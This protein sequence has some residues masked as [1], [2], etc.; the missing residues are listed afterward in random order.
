MSQP[1]KEQWADIEK[2]LNSLFS[3]TYL[4]CDGYL[5]A[6]EMVLDKN[7]LVIQV[8]VDGL[9]KG[10]WHQY[11]ESIEEFKE[12]PK[13]FYCLKK[14]SLWPKK[15]I[16]DMEKIIGKRRCKSEGYYAVR[17]TSRC[18]WNSAKSFI[19]HLKKH[20]QSIELLDHKT[21]Q[22]RLAAKLPQEQTA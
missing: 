14:T 13:R 7:K 15:V 20:N 11:V 19:S 8:Y 2:Q 17:Y 5:I 12:E 16:T 10:E 21:Y 22:Q 3:T 9:I 18:W 4:D 1:T 6:A